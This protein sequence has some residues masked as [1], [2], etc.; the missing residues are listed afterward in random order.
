MFGDI[1]V[2]RFCSIAS[3]VSIIAGNHPLDHLTTH[4]FTYNDEMFGDNDEYRDIDF[5]KTPRAETKLPALNIG[6]DVWIGTQVIILG[7]VQ[8]IGNGAVIGAGAVVTKN[9]PPYAV[10][11]GNPAR[12]I[13]YRFDDA[14]IQDLEELKW[15]ELPLP[16]IKHLDFSDVESCI[17]EL[18]A[19]RK[20]SAPDE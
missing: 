11:A 9:V 1:V 16:R 15:W 2:G 7:N 19:I 4:P 18:K 13:K 12:I 17:K 6:N 14:T 5:K 3:G 20:E 8:S 10:V